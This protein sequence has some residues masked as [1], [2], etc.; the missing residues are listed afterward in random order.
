[1]PSNSQ[2]MASIEYVFARDL[3]LFLIYLCFR[4]SAVPYEI[5]GQDRKRMLFS[6]IV[7]KTQKVAI[8]P[9]EYCGNA[10]RVNIG[11]SFVLVL[12]RKV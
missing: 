2:G 4:D 9:L 12:F 1:M 6:Y 11:S 5:V 10:H 7:E 3:A 8:G